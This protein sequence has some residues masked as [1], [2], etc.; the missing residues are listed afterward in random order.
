MS[1]IATVATRPIQT[2]WCWDA[3]GR[4]FWYR[5]IV[6]SVEQALNTPAK[7]LIK[8][9]SSPATTIPR[10]P[11]GKACLTISGNAAWHCS[12]IGLPFASSRTFNPSTCPVLARAKQSMPGMMKMKTGSSFRN[13]AKMVPRR[14]SR[15][16]GAPRA[17]WTMYWSVHQYHKPTIGAQNSMPN[18]G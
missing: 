6:N 10:T 7:E 18:Q 5:S 11:T 14:A 3:P 15:S 8:A 1:T 12:A 13:A 4:S 9:A 2:N 16:L 17:R